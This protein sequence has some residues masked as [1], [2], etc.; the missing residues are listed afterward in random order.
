MPRPERHSDISIRVEFSL[1]VTVLIPL[2]PFLAA[3][4][5]YCLTGVSLSPRKSVRILPLQQQFL[6]DA[7]AVR[8]VSDPLGGCEQP[9][10]PA[11]VPCLDDDPQCSLDLPL[12][13]VGEQSS[14][15]L[16]EMGEDH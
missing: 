7:L 12:W 8:W 16:L 14:Q 3:F 9:V 13:Q 10:M 2:S 4:A 15:A 5:P 6:P 1:R 11:V